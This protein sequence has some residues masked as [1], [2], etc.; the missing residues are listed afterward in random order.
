LFLFVDDDQELSVTNKLSMI[1]LNYYF[2]LQRTSVYV[3]DKDSKDVVCDIGWKVNKKQNL[4]FCDHFNNY[5]KKKDFKIQDA[6][7]VVFQAIKS[8]KHYFVVV[9]IYITN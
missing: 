7:K 1:D 2:S 9:L 4:F 5:Q 8:E 6:R 3:R